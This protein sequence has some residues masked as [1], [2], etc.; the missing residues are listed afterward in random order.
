[1]PFGVL[2]NY[3]SHAYGYLVII[4]TSPVLLSAL[5]S[6]GWGII[7]LLAMAQM[8]LGVLDAGVTPTLIHVISKHQQGMYPLETKI[9]V[10]SLRWLIFL[11]SFIFLVGAVALIDPLS[12]PWSIKLVNANLPV[13][14][15]LIILL[16]IVTCLLRL[17]SFVARAAVL[18]DR[19]QVLVASLEIGINTARFPLAYF[20]LIFNDSMNVTNFLYTQLFISIF[21]F[22]IYQILVSRSIGVTLIPGRLMLTSL[23]PVKSLLGVSAV[24]TL[25]WLFLSQLDRL[26]FS[27][28]LGLSEFGYF[29]LVA[30]LCALVLGFPAPLGRAVLPML[31]R[32]VAK[33]EAIKVVEIYRASTVFTVGML[34][35][36]VVA[37]VLFPEKLL[38]A[39]LSD[40]AAITWISLI[41]PW[42]FV[43]AFC[44]AIMTFQYYLQVATG[45]LSYHLRYNIAS[46]FVTVPA[47][48]MAFREFGI[49]ASALVL[50]LLK[51]LPLVIW[52][53]FIHSRFA[54]G[55]GKKWYFND[56]FEPLMISLL[57]MVVLSQFTDRLLPGY[58]YEII[59]N[60]IISMVV[61]MA[62]MLKQHRFKSIV[63]AY[64]ND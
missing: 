37:G 45:D 10:N 35:S 34:G 42:Y 39:W 36:F 9:I 13:D 62:S 7:S 55:L 2:F 8:W 50:M 22:L 58:R 27:V 64:Y 14:P 15:A 44:V 38:G 26:V 3:F 57:V 43:G 60:I 54:N 51:V 20:I 21:E 25:I 24:S 23:Y 29:T 16:I 61:T 17:N 63:S 52:L 19:R 48:L 53:P 28:S 12:N 6:E 30:S 49:V 47:L 31:T 41:L 11:F 4:L 32:A 5:G 33:D 56:I 46:V 1:L 40:E 18:A 59:I